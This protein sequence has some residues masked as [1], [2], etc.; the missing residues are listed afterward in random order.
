MAFCS[1]ILHNFF[2]A[3][4]ALGLRRKKPR[5]AGFVEFGE[6]ID[7]ANDRAFSYIKRYTPVV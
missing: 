4:Q 6:P 5:K 3:T 1:S 7:F 2:F